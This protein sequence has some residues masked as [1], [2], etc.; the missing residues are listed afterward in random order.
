M[1]KYP[2]EQVTASISKDREILKN[3]I[4][5]A[6]PVRARGKGYRGVVIPPGEKKNRTSSVDCCPAII[7]A[8]SRTR[9][10]IALK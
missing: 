9:D 6:G 10:D 3:L 1:M 5:N 8:V 4:R 7:S 2:H